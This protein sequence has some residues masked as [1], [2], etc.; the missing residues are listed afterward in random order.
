LRFI[1]RACAGAGRRATSGTGTG[2]FR[3]HALLR[4]SHPKV[5]VAGHGSWFARTRDWRLTA[6][7]RRRPSD[8]PARDGARIPRTTSRR[9]PGEGRD[10]DRGIHPVAFSRR[11]SSQ[12]ETLWLWI[13]AF[14]GTTAGLLAQAK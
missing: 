4:D 12:N 11:R 10:P 8:L 6:P 13:P 7:S 3:R 2:L 5:Q 9:R 1:D 14:A